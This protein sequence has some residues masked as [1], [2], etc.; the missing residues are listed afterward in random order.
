[1]PDLQAVRHGSFPQLLLVDNSTVQLSMHDRTF[2]SIRPYSHSQTERHPRTISLCTSRLRGL[3]DLSFDTV[4]N[5]SGASM[6]ARFGASSCLHVPSSPRS[7]LR[8]ELHAQRMNRYC[9]GCPHVSSR[10]HSV[11]ADQHRS[12]RLLTAASSRRSQDQ[13]PSD[14][15][16]I[17]H[18][19]ASKTFGGLRQNACILTTAAAAVMLLH[20]AGRPYGVCIPNASRILKLRHSR[21]ASSKVFQG[22]DEAAATIE[23][24]CV[25][26]IVM[27]P[28][29]GPAIASADHIQSAVRVFDLADMDA[30]TAGTL[31]R[32]LQPL[33]AV[34]QL[35]MISRIVLS[36]YPQVAFCICVCQV[37]VELYGCASG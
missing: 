26:L 18:E 5:N 1:M 30:A 11:N 32:I 12:P 28:G 2:S 34:S 37:D 20:S 15:I 33:L 9:M 36:W 35:L 8:R 3:S 27:F 16:S 7:I 17:S 24:A 25:T 13:P 22:T 4:S 29:A 31:A 23:S 10:S 6:A 14:P 19:H 21:C